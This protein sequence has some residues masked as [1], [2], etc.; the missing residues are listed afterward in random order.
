MAKKN[1]KTANT[2]GQRTKLKV[3]G[4]ARDLDAAESKKVRGGVVA[5]PQLSV[6]MGDGSVRPALPA[7]QDGTSNTILVGL[8]K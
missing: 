2:S 3:L 1:T 6:G 5:A 4:T 8:R 7:V